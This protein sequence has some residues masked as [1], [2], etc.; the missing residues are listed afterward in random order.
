[1]RCL[2]KRRLWKVSRGL[3]IR[4]FSICHYVRDNYTLAD[5]LLAGWQY[6]CR[7]RHIC[8]IVPLFLL[9]SLSLSLSSMSQSQSAKP[10]RSRALTLRV[11]QCILTMSDKPRFLPGFSR[12]G[13]P[14]MKMFRRRHPQG[15]R[16]EIAWV[17]KFPSD[18]R[19]TARDLAKSPFKDAVALIGLDMPLPA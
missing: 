11:F 3:P 6:Y 18:R 13:Y 7:V 15:T 1:M 9:L 10:C 17:Y 19:G 2:P 12:S 16:P 5:A 14:P 4:I 8:M